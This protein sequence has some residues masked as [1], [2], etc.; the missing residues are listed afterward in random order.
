MALGKS[1]LQDALEPLKRCW[2]EC[3]SPGLRE[4]VML[5]IAMLRLPSAIDCLLDIVASESEKDAALSMSALKIHNY[6]PRL[7]E[8]LSQIVQ[9]KGSRTLQLLFDRDFRSEEG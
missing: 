3:V 9:K 6:D 5:A 1:R 8:R 4:Q 2:Q 7:R